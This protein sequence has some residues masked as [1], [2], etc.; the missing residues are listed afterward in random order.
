MKKLITIGILVIAGIIFTGSNSFN[1]HEVNV[2]SPA[3]KLEIPEN[4]QAVID[5]S[6]FG[7]HNSESRNEE[8]RLK[9]KFDKLSSLKTFKLIGVLEEIKTEVDSAGMP[10][11]KF[12][13]K[14]PDAALSAEDKE[15]LSAWAGETAAKLGAK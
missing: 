13:N 5:K 2:P 15:L 14:Y 10:P 6:C 7:C 12:L 11:K 1:T 3:D 9:L 8:A 4:V